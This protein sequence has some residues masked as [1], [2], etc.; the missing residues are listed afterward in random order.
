MKRGEM[1]TVYNWTKQ[2]IG[3]FI[4]RDEQVVEGSFQIKHVI[5]STKTCQMYKHFELLWAYIMTM[6]TA[7]NWSLS[8]VK[9]DNKSQEQE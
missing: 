2:E 4:F 1:Q 6:K 7:I 5:Q 3:Q 8:V 9:S